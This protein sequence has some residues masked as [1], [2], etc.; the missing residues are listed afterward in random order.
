M[1]NKLDYLS[2]L[3]I[4]KIEY[5]YNTLVAIGFSGGIYKDDQL[6]DSIPASGLNGTWNRITTTDDETIQT[7]GFKT[8]KW[9]H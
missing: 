3:L 7:N 5:E 2:G 1:Y 9:Q 4:E 8:E 6:I